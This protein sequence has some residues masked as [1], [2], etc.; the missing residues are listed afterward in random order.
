[1]S[2]NLETIKDKIRKLL[3]LSKSD[4]ENEAAAALEKANNLLAEYELD[5]SALRFE[6]VS[7]KSTK[8]FVKWRTVV[9]NAVSWL[10]GCYNYIDGD[11][12]VF[13]FTGEGINSFMAGEMFDYLIQTIERCAKKAIRK[14][15]K[16]KFR[17][18]FKY[19]MASRLY[20][21]IIEMGKACSWLSDREIKKE[22]AEEYVK[23]LIKL[24]ECKG[25]KSNFNKRALARGHLYGDNVSLAR[26]TGFTPVAHL[27]GT[28]KTQT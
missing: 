24:S 1:M 11:K 9:A 19:G 22:E 27:P 15:A 8:T 2:S 25:K 7:V 5:E 13:T 4:N 3:A 17:R 6:Q 23:S 14:N 10:Y 20:N 16:L 18:D 28:R 12:G 21:R 26:Q